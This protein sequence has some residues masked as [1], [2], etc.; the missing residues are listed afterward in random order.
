MYQLGVIAKTK[1]ILKLTTMENNEVAPPAKS[2]NLIASMVLICGT[3]IIVIII[4]V[5]LLTTTAKTASDT[6][7]EVFHS[8]LPVISAWIGTVLAFYFG[9]ENFESAT[10]QFNT[11][12]NKITPEQFK[13]IPVKQVMIDFETM[14]KL[15]NADPS[16]LNVEQLAPYFSTN[17]DKSRLPIVDKDCKP[18]F[19]IHKDEYDNLRKDTANATRLV[20]SFN[21]YGLNE[22]KGFV[23]IAESATLNDAQQQIKKIATVQ[24]VFITQNGTKDEA[25]TGWLTDGRILNYLQ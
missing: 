16:Q 15:P 8:M 10:R 4:I 3:G 7:R 12:V 14:I 22:P 1:S 23:L 20:A 24:D 5:L 6:A 25:L 21:Q 19:V 11:L 13:S 2:R 18:L 9:K 17:T